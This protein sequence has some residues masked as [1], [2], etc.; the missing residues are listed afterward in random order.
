MQEEY[1]LSKKE[2]E[3]DLFESGWKLENNSLQKEYV[4]RN[5]VEVIDFLNILWS[6]FEEMH[7]HPDF[8][9]RFNRISF[10]IR[11]HEKNMV[12]E[13]DFVAAQLIENV[14]LCLAER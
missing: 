2:I 8:T 5:F 4:F 6:F 14:Y 7:H 1:Y 11:S 9:V 3:D 12:T 13:K 10:S